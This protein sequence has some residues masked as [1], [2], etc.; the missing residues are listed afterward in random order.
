MTKSPTAARRQM[1][2]RSVTRLAMRN[3]ADANDWIALI[4]IASRPARRNRDKL[5][6]PRRLSTFLLA[7]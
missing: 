7:A 5:V 3:T 4:A 2:A 6:P 1:R